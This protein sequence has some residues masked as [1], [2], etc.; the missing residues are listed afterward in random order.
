MDGTIKQI[1]GDFPVR[2]DFSSQIRQHTRDNNMSAVDILRNPTL[3]YWSQAPKLAIA[4]DEEVREETT[5]QKK[6]R[7][8]DGGR[9]TNKRNKR[10]GKS[11]KKHRKSNKKSSRKRSRK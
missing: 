9:R 2:G 10:R 8:L 3:A 1:L 5:R 6:L 11:H 7:K 4:R